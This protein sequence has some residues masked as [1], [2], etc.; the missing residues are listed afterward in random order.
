MQTIRPIST[1]YAIDLIEFKINPMEA[2]EQGE[3][4]PVAILNRNQPVFYC[5]P[6]D[7]Y[8]AMMDKLEDVELTSLFEERQNQ[9]E[10]EINKNDL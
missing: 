4:F 3:G 7:A 2:V 5:V 9:P 10:I 8:E 6:A 1:D